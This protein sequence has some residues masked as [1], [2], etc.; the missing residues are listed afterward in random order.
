MA[1]ALATHKFFIIWT[2]DLS[3]GRKRMHKMTV[4]IFQRGLFVQGELNDKRK[5]C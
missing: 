2:L 4:Q 5:N 1:E 3:T